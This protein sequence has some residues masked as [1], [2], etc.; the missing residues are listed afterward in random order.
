MDLFP[1]FREH[2]NSI[3]QGE[4]RPVRI[5][6]LR[7]DSLYI[8]VLRTMLRFYFGEESEGGRVLM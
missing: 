3:P 5:S 4:V 6:F 8:R 7:R 1:T 2:F